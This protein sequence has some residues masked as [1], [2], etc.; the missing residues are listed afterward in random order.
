MWFSSLGFIPV[1]VSEMAMSTE[2]SVSDTTIFISPFEGVNLKALE[3]RLLKT[4]CI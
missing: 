1:P 2:L 4:F 3:S